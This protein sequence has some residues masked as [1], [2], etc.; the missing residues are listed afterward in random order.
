MNDVQSQSFHY[1][2]VVEI[3]WVV[4]TVRA[5]VLEVHGYPGNE[6]VLLEVPDVDQEASEPSPSPTRSEMCGRSPQPE[7]N[8]G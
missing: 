4:G 2:D 5:R 3:P 7:L 8:T 6:R 1:G